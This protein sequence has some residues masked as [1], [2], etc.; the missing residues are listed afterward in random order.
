MS[1]GSDGSDGRM[2]VVGDVAARSAVGVLMRTGDVVGSLILVGDELEW[3][4]VVVMSVGVARRVKI[5]FAILSPWWMLYWELELL[6]ILTWTTPLK[7]GLMVPRWMVM[8]RLLEMLE[9]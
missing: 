4:E 9:G 5:I 6:W 7:S 2:D 1:S 8:L 3:M